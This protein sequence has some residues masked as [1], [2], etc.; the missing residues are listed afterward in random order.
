MNFSAKRNPHLHLKPQ[1]RE[2]LPNGE[3][4][5]LEVLKK[6]SKSVQRK[7]FKTV[8]V[9]LATIVLMRLAQAKIW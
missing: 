6:I 4:L 2:S 7:I 9:V 1:S 5:G 8:A 3:E